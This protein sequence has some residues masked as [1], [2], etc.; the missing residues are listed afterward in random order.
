MWYVL[1]AAQVA[2]AKSVDIPVCMVTRLIWVVVIYSQGAN[3][4]LTSGQK[5]EC[6]DKVLVWTLH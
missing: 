2:A 6:K 1:M 4:K 5:K 3:K